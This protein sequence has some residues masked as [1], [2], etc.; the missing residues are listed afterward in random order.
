MDKMRKVAKDSEA[1]AAALNIN[2]LGKVFNAFGFSLSGWL[3]SLLQSLIM[4]VIIIIAI[5]IV[6]SC[7]KRMLMRSVSIV[8]YAPLELTERVDTPIDVPL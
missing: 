6:I 5:C 8:K 4:I 7:V 2:W 1:I 3:T